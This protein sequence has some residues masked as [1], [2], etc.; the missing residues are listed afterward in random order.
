MRHYVVPVRFSGRIEYRVPVGDGGPDEAMA[1]AERLA[2]EEGDFSAMED[3]D[4]E[5]KPPVA[6]VSGTPVSEPKARV[7]VAVVKASAVR[8]VQMDRFDGSDP[9]DDA[10]WTDV[11]DAELYAGTY[12]GTEAEAVARAAE[13]METHPSN[14]LLRPVDGT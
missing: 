1:A 6:M 4:F 10:S 13:Y 8:D 2:N 7:Y 5:V 9:M 14:I 11:P 12:R 3:I